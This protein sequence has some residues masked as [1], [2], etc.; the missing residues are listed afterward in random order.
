MLLQ[1]IWK[2]STLQFGTKYL[3]KIVLLREWSPESIPIDRDYLKHYIIQ[4]LEFF[5][6]HAWTDVNY[7][8]LMED[9][10]L[11]WDNFTYESVSNNRWFP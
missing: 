10:L 11:A 5:G 9:R 6:I 2:Q 1:F 8:E 4:R 3:E 7:L